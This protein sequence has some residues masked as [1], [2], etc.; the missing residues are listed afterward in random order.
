[1][2]REFFFIRD[3]SMELWH[4]DESCCIPTNI[5]VILNPSYVMSACIWFPRTADFRGYKMHMDIKMRAFFSKWKC[6]KSELIELFFTMVGCSGKNRCWFHSFMLYLSC[7]CNGLL[8]LL[9]WNY[10]DVRER[11]HSRIV[12]IQTQV[13]IIQGKNVFQGD[14]HG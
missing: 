10:H 3:K 4:C 13:H 6:V 12:L 5:R 1:M 2:F 8:P 11:V 9:V 7:P 14:N